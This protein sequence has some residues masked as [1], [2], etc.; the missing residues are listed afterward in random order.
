MVNLAPLSLFARVQVRQPRRGRP[1][2]PVRRVRAI[3]RG[4]DAAYPV[5]SD[6]N[7]PR[8]DGP[9]LIEPVAQGA[10]LQGAVLLACGAVCRLGNPTAAIAEER[11]HDPRAVAPIPFVGRSAC[12]FRQNAAAEVGL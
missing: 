2:C 5:S 8:Y 11:L 6:V 4:P 3:P 9:D 12:L 1:R 10:A 7:A